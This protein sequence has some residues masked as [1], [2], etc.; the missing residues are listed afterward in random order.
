[1]KGEKDGGIF[2]Q[3]WVPDV[4][5]SVTLQGL[6]RYPFK[7]L[8]FK[9][10]FSAV[11][12]EFLVLGQSR[13][14]RVRWLFLFARGFVSGKILSEKAIFYS[15]RCCP[16]GVWF[17]GLVSTGKLLLR[18]GVSLALCQFVPGL[19]LFS[20]HRRR[21]HKPITCCTANLF[22]P[23]R[24]AMPSVWMW[25]SAFVTP[26]HVRGHK[27]AIPPWRLG[28]IPQGIMMHDSTE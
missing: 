15:V 14:P 22:I 7:L 13:I 19:L 23:G 24:N 3:L 10:F 25:S 17:G 11:P 5:L 16:L 8:Q 2:T 21:S 12:P 26:V 6:L 28:S 4:L 1:M 9:S 18:C 27:S 20:V